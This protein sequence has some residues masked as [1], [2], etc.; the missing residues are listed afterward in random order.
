MSKNKLFIGLLIMLV[1]AG[2]AGA[3]AFAPV[4][5]DAFSKG[6]PE[7]PQTVPAWEQVNSSG[8]G[9]PKTGEVSAVE[10]FDGN[11]YAGTFNPIDPAPGQLYDGAQ[12]F[13]SADGM[14]WNPVT[15]PGFG[16]THDTAPPA[17][18]DLTVFKG[19]L[20]A[21][22]GRG[23]AAQIWRSVDGV[24]WG[25][26]VN[27]G[28]GDPDIVDLTVMAEYNGWLYVGA[29]KQDNEAQI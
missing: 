23:N 25:P 27:A 29:R 18:L 7:Q 10:A 4:N 8:F 5:L 17:I 19:Y 3:S 28:F 12:I 26:V 22:T 14:N 11:L 2:M 6:V 16:N 20:F 9:D 24:N 21:S 13:Q 1:L 15:D